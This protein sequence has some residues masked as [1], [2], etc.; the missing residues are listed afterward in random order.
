MTCIMK[1][2]ILALATAGLGL[3]DSWS[4]HLVAGRCK[5]GAH[6]ATVQPRKGCAPTHT[7][8]FGIETADGSVYRLD[9][10]G[11][12]KA[13]AALKEDPSKTNITVSGAFDGQVVHVDSI[14]FK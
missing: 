1:A 10:S 12:K 11:N 5:Q 8:V 9:D 14:V 4:G 2:G 7:K 3:S 13:L 6:G